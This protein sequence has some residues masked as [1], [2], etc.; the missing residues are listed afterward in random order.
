MGA[1][2]DA[3][4]CLDRGEVLL[5]DVDNAVELG[6]LLC[7]R[8]EALA[9]I[10]PDGARCALAEAERLAADAGAGPD[11]ELGRRIP[12]SAPC[13]TRRT[14]GDRQRPTTMRSHHC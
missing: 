11:S 12:W 7:H 9:E 4:A 2:S 5:R 1:G 6:K 8:A 13:S 3:L 14:K 10:D